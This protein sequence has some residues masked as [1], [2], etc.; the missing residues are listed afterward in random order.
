VL[1]NR[2]P[3]DPSQQPQSPALKRVRKSVYKQALLAGLLIM[4]TVVTLFAVTAAWYTNIV[5]SNDLV[6]KA[7][8]WSFDGTV[9]S[10]DVTVVASPGDE[11]VV[12]LIAESDS[13]GVT[14]VGVNISKAQMPMEMQKRIYFYVDTA[15]TRGGEAMDRI[16]LGSDSSY[17]YLLY[18]RDTLTLTEEKHT[19]APLKWQ[20][21]YDVVG[22]YVQGS[23][24]GSSMTVAE[25]LRPIEYDYDE[26]T[27]ASDGKLETVD[28]SK[29]TARFLAE[30]SARDGYPGTI[31]P[32][33][34]NSGGYYPVSVDDSG[35]GVWAY[36]CTYSE[37]QANTALDTYLGEEAATGDQPSFVAKL[38]LSAQN[39]NLEP[40]QVGT[41]AELAAAL[42]SGA[43]AAVRLSSDLT[44][45]DAL[46]IGTA[47]DPRQVMLDLNGKTL[48]VESGSGAAIQVAAGS[49]LTMTNGTLTGSA[50]G[51]A[52]E[53]AGAGITLSNMDIVGM[54]RALVVRD[55][56]ASN[57]TNSD[58]AI[59]LVDCDIETTDVAILI[60]GNGSDSAQATRLVVEDSTIVSSGY[61]GIAFNGSA[62]QWGTATQ[63]INSQVYGKWAGVYHPQGDAELVISDGSTISGY[64]GLVLKG[65]ST[66][67]S[68]S[69]VHGTGALQVPET[70]SLSG[71][72][73]T[74]DSIYIESNYGGA[75]QLQVKGSS[76]LTSDHAQALR[77]YPQSDKVSVSVDDSVTLAGAVQ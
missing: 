59:R 7:S 37:I 54:K 75:I 68:D 42:N 22:Y 30:L 2:R 25:Y 10:A 24:D 69:T 31:D 41:A 58:A 34:K 61:I 64:T 29:T 8:K 17:T 18:G 16:Y 60:S 49:G 77:V 70:V 50:D 57:T 11:G 66:T 52:I 53:G 38:T 56:S 3:S 36:L 67:V 6:F 5:Q 40:T 48:T 46:T 39:S 65:G 35:N 15:K 74:G 9:K 1:N 44:L 32:A 23:W 71:F 62:D 76:T 4:L 20:W 45:E 43:D 27:F 63:I 51:Y 72:N 33:Q 14:A 73:D 26:A 47:A 19:D 28:G 55:N 13:D 21:V 12:E